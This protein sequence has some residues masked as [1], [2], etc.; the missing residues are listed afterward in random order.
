MGHSFPGWRHRVEVITE[1]I[2]GNE[3]LCTHVSNPTQRLGQIS[4][5][6]LFC[7]IVQLYFQELFSFIANL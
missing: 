2:F 7:I 6:F 4:E 3:Y 1:I 5:F